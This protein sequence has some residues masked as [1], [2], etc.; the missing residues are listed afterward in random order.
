M[1]N[2]HLIVQ[3]CEQA[4]SKKENLFTKL[5]RTDLSRRTNDFQHPNSI[6]NSLPL[7]KQS[8]NKQVD[9]FKAL[10]LEK[11]YSILEYAED[12]VDNWLVN[13][14]VYNKEIDQALHNI[15]INFRELENKLFNIKICNEMNV[16]PMR[17]YIEE[18][19]ERELKQT[20]NKRKQAVVRIPAAIDNIIE[21]TV[22]DDINETI[23]ISK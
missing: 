19:L 21:T 15:S 20:A 9:I 11:F 14:L 2:L 23:A 18:W 16:S 12:D 4:I 6:V 7:T 8:F 13:Y 3:S 17:I 10:S 22:V 1:K 5:T